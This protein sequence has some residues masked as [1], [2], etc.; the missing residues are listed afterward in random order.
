MTDSSSLVE[1]I[2]EPELARHRADHGESHAA[3]PHRFSNRGRP[4]KSFFRSGA[5][6]KPP[7]AAQALLGGDPSPLRGHFV[8]HL[9]IFGINAANRRCPH[10]RSPCEIPCFTVSSIRASP[11]ATAPSPVHVRLLETHLFP[12]RSPPGLFA[13]LPGQQTTAPLPKASNVYTSTLRKPAHSSAAAS[14]PRC[15]TTFPS[16]SAGCAPGCAQR[17][18]GF[19][20]YFQRT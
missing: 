6:R 4:L 14:P 2:A 7:A 18:P 5:P 15:P 17:G 10:H 16:W 11:A 13:G 20:K 19:A 9:S 3:I 8:A 12:A 1:I